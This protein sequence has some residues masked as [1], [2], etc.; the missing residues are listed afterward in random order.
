[1][2][3]TYDVKSVENS[4]YD[5]WVQSNFFTPEYI[6]PGIDSSLFLS[7]S[8]LTDILGMTQEEHD[9]LDK[10][11]MVI[12]PPNVTGVLHIGHALTSSIQDTVVRFHRYQFL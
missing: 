4:W 1:M 9:A 2:A 8:N 5:W 3:P 12:P 10:F 7:N 11:V 6:R